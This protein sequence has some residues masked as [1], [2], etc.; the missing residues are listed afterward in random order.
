MMDRERAD[1][2]AVTEQLKETFGQGAVATQLP[3]GAEDKF[4]GV[5]DLL[6]LKAFSYKDGKASERPV[7]ED[8]ASQVE[9][10]REKL[11]DAVAENDDAIMEKYLE[12]EEIK[13]EELLAALKAGV[14]AGNIFPIGVGCATK[15]A[16]VDLLLDLIIDAIPSPARRPEVTVIDAGT[17][18]EVKLKCKADGPLAAFVF[19]TLADPFSGRIN[20]LRVFSGELKSD[21]N[22]YNPVSKTKERIGQLLRLQGKDNSPVEALGLGDIGAI[23]KLKETKTGDSLASESKQLTFPALKFPAPVM[24]FAL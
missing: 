10:Y 9:E 21:S 22:V 15:G 11:M 18:E 17:G 1:F 19:K 20:V 2:F 24:S 4:E 8:M 7:P 5:V 6:S 23:A 14:A 16:G 3:I 13:K 12:G